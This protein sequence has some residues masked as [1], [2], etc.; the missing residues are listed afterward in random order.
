M[1][2]TA[3][4]TEPQPLPM[5]SSHTSIFAICVDILHRQ[6]NSL[7]TYVVSKLNHI[8]EPPSIWVTDVITCL[9]SSVVDLE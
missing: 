7:P 5:L 6:D 3:L 1:E 4:P 9:S 2:A 8:L